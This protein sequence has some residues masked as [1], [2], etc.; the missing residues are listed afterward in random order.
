MDCVARTN[1]PT[2]SY[3]PSLSIAQIQ[4]KQP[5]LQ[6]SRFFRHLVLYTSVPS[7]RC[8]RFL[9][10]TVTLRR[11]IQMAPAKDR[12]ASGVS[13]THGRNSDVSGN[14]HIGKEIGEDERQ[15][16]EPS[17]IWYAATVFPLCSASFG[18]LGLAFSI[19]ALAED[20]RITI[21]TSGLESDEVFITDPEWLVM[22]LP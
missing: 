20:W 10:R 17:H 16:Y 9:Q 19:C 8:S 7:L 2:T 3:F 21:P 15:Y 18:P 6:S 1:K 5:V 22:I 4:G 13:R 11:H 12:K 14:E